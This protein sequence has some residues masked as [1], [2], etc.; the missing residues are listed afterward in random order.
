MA[1]APSLPTTASYPSERLTIGCGAA[2]FHLASSRVVFCHHSRDN[3]YFLPKGRKNANES[4]TAAAER[5][6]FEETGY[7]NRLLP[8]PLVHRQT[9]PDDGF[10]EFVREAIW[11]QLLPLPAQ[12]VQYILYWYAA[13]TVPS[14]VEREYGT[15]ANEGSEVAGGVGRVYRSPPRF[16]KDLTINAR[17]QQDM[18]S[19]GS[20]ERDIYEP[21]RHEGTG[22]DEE[23]ALYRSSL[24]PIDEALRKLRGTIMAD[25]VRRAWEAVQLRVQ[26]EASR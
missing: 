19:D 2:I 21:V 4:H 25:V 26:I 10:V 12:A 23:E 15:V 5:E 16:P 13:E 3:Y 17:I 20:S 14:N 22:V 9:Q 6:G 7:R 1:S 18:V 11:V 8:L 24:V